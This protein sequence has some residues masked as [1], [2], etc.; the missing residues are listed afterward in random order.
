MASCRARVLFRRNR[1]TD[2]GGGGQVW[3]QDRRGS[4]RTGVGAGQV[5]EQKDRCGSRRTG[6]GAEGQVWEQEDR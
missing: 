4:R 3:E 1:R 2:V 6:V 5:S